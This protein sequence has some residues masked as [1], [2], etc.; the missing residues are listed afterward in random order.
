MDE[1]LS[2][3]EELYNNINTNE[4]RMKEITNTI[5]VLDTVIEYN[6]E[7]L[8]VL[9]KEKIELDDFHKTK[10]EKIIILLKQLREYKIES[11]DNKEI[12]D[13]IEELVRLLLKLNLGSDL[14]LDFDSDSDSG[15]VLGEN[16][17]L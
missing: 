17:E 8:K 10:K 1:I 5:S 4:L 7:Y 14:D 9:T 11:P 3:A 6:E 2:N 16:E 15:F 12:D 13:I